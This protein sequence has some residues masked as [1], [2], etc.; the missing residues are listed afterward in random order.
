MA[1]IRDVY[2][3]EF[4]SATFDAQVQAAINKVNELSEAMENGA[5]SSED[6]DGAINDLV[7]TTKKEATGIDSLNAKRNVLVKS[8]QSLNKESKAYTVVGSQIQATNSRIAQSTGA[9]TVQ[10]KSFFASLLQ[11]A[12]NLNSMR[13]AASLVAGVFRVIAGISVFG[14]ITQA[15]PF[16]IGLF[17]KLFGAAESTKSALDKLND[18][19]TGL[20]ERKSILEAELTRFKVLEERSGE[21]TEEQ[22]QQRDDLQQKY[23]E[24]AEEITRIE[25]ER[26]QRIQKLELDSARLRAKL[27]TNE[28]ER[29]RELAKLDIAELFQD[30]G[31]QQTAIIREINKLSGERDKAISEQRVNDADAI[32]KQ[33]ALLQ[34]ESDSLFENTKL[35]KLTIQQEQ[36]AAQGR[37]SSATKLATSLAVLEEE[38]SK[39]QKIQ[40]EQ[41][42]ALDQ[43]ALEQ[44]QKQIDAQQDKVD[45]A[46]ALLNDIR[47]VA[48]AELNIERLK[49]QLIV[50]DTDRKIIELRKA[51]IS[52]QDAVVGTAEQ[53]A[54]QIRLI[55]AKLNAD[56]AELE[57][58]RTEEQ[59]K[60]EEKRLNDTIAR[61]NEALVQ[62]KAFEE[63]KT[64]ITLQGIEQRRNAELQQ[65][66]NSG[67][68]AEK[69]NEAVEQVNK[70][71]DAERVAAEKRKNAI[72]LQAEI[73]AVENIL[74]VRQQLGLSTSEQ[75]AEIEKLK[76]AL[77][78]LGRIDATVEV[79]AKTEKAQ[80]KIKQFINEVLPEIGKIADQI[81]DA[82]SQGYQRLI[83]NLDNAIGKSKSALD[84]IR[85]N[86]ENF[87]ARQLELEKSRLEKLEQER[88]KAVEREKA[89]ALVQLVANS[90]VAVAKAAA[91]G[92]IAAPFTIASTI[93]ALLAGFAAARS[94]A[95][96]AFFHGTEFVSRDGKYP[97]GRD[98]IPA[99][100]NEGEAVIPT[101]TNKEYRQAI[102][103][104]Y[105]GKIPASVMNEFV[106]NWNR[107]ESVMQ[108]AGGQ[109]MVMGGTDNSG[110][111][112]RMERLE[113]VLLDLPSKMPRVQVVGN[114]GGMM[115]VFETKQARRETV[116]RIVGRG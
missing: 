85:Q 19:E 59:Q 23:K 20:Q 76:L 34:Q 16:V 114:F 12:R 105:N 108:T 66:A 93:I 36:A 86:S 30:T 65:V 74:E 39:L 45:K 79:D 5:A 27:L 82:V 62:D 10:N 61:I 98:T 54:E 84:E 37:L 50:D 38:L 107:P 53:K 13:R 60:A 83:Q 110:L 63:Q 49:N 40:R 96:N 115:R 70:K 104:I 3:L 81:F 97:A 14:L 44:I 57:K 29:T 41:R 15:I 24:T 64:L 113:Q 22:K 103:A 75:Q 78:E 43:G 112:S 92:G 32:S 100:L 99:M 94:A 33:I 26:I 101:A 58:K 48:D 90:T 67:L 18:P 6:L 51:A 8:Q 72:I 95:G 52:E 17:Q 55:E 116:K 25:T 80:G 1:E 111:E 102:S 28:S 7:T 21:L 42:D 46:K 71:Y 31:A 77:I 4:D 91:E 89:I 47:G 35:R 2:S 68:D 109:I 56:I 73:Q 88:A 106:H 87:N 11:G 9:A 69:R